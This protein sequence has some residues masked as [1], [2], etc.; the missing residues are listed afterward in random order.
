MTWKNRKVTYKPGGDY[1]VQI[2][3]SEELVESLAEKIRDRKYKNDVDISLSI[4]SLGLANAIQHRELIASFLNYQG[5]S[6][7]AASAIGVLFEDFGLT[8]EYLDV[9]KKAIKGSDWDDFCDF[10]SKGITC[11]GRYLNDKFDRDLLKLL[12][13]RF[14][15]IDEHSFIR[16][17]V[18]ESIA[19]AMGRSYLDTPPLGATT[20]SIE[21]NRMDLLDPTIME[22]AYKKLAEE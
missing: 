17:E 9:V 19:L 11:A 5:E 7:V 6:F 16:A 14:E 15:D 13:E 1:G 8:S 2:P 3:S 22:W 10:Q 20:L 12:V 18:L 4:Q 21:E